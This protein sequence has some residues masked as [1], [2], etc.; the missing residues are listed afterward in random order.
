MSLTCKE[1]R[2]R[3]LN[4]VN[5]VVYAA[6]KAALQNK[7][8]GKHNSLRNELITRIMLQYQYRTFYIHTRLNQLDVRI[9]DLLYRLST[10]SSYATVRKDSQTQLFSLLSHY[11]Y[12]NLI[13]VP[14][15]IEMLKRCDRTD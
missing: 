4:C 6:N 9:I 2:N 15:I 7:L 1:E 8:L 12:S 3:E 13:I 11:S 14:K 5:H 10:N